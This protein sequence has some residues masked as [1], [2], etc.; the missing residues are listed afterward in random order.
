MADQTNPWD[1]TPAA[2]VPHKMLMPGVRHQA[3]PLTVVARTG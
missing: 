1:T 3:H 2:T